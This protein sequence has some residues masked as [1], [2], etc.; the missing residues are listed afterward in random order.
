M[1]G[2]LRSISLPLSVPHPQPVSSSPREYRPPLPP[3]SAFVSPVPSEFWPLLFFFSIPGVRRRQF[4]FGLN[5]CLRAWTLGDKRLGLRCS[6]CRLARRAKGGR[7]GKGRQG[8]EGGR[9]S[10]S[11]E[12]LFGLIGRSAMFH[13]P[14]LGW[15]LLHVQLTTYLS[16]PPP[17]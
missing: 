7:G 1:G 8:L 3:F 2:Y 14:G 6:T 11:D 17:R 10:R 9:S 5:S 16:L 12:Q 13:D 15:L 4:W